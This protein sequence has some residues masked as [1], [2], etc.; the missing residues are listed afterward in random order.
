MNFSKLVH[1][2]LGSITTITLLL[3]AYNLIRLVLA[4]EEK[5]PVFASG[6]KQWAI[7]S[8]ALLG[9]YFIWILVKRSF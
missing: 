2:I 6:L 4:P 9:I 1:I 7:W 5:K 8:V 3:T